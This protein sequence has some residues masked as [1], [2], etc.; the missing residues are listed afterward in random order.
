MATSLGRTL[1]DLITVFKYLKGY[2]LED[3]DL[4]G[5]EPEEKIKTKGGS[6][7]KTDLELNKKKKSFAAGV[8]GQCNMGPWEVVSSPALKVFKQREFG[9]GL[10]VFSVF[11][12][13]FWKVGTLLF[14]VYIQCLACT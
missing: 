13:S 1:W 6:Y 5:V 7:K 9:E 8:I 12:M 3:R 4:F 2:H 11:L 14:N 10:L